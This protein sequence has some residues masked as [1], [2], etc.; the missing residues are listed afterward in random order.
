M[1]VYENK[2]NFV[3]FKSRSKNIQ[4]H[5]PVGI[6]LFFFFVLFFY[7]RNIFIHIVVLRPISTFLYLF[8]LKEIGQLNKFFKVHPFSLCD[9]LLQHPSFT[10]EEDSLCIRYLAS[11][12]RAF[13]AHG[14]AISTTHYMATRAEGCGDFVIHANLTDPSVLEVPN[15]DL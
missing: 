13:F 7:S 11:T 15:H 14:R 8:F 6:S 10:R 3:L 5:F 1:V 4:L 9:C 12:Q 2:F